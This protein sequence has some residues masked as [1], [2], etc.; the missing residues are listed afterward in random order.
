MTSTSAP[1]GP[2]TSTD[3]AAQAARAADLITAAAA[4]WLTADTIT[5]IGQAMAV[6]I[7]EHRRVTGLPPTWADA[8]T[9]IDPT[10]LAP[11]TTPPGGWPAQPAVWRRQLRLRLM[12]QLKQTRWVTYTPTPG[13]LRVADRGRDWLTATANPTTTARDTPTPPPSR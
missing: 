7:T 10:L 5:A 2:T 12:T 11:M 8:L 1:A 3:R 4:A 9:G 13:S 6:C